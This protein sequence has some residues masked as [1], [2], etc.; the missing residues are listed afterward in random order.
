MKSKYLSQ[1]E[2]LGPMAAPAPGEMTT[3]LDMTSVQR[4]MTS[5]SSFFVVSVGSLR[6]QLV[7][8][9]VG[10]AQFPAGGSMPAESPATEDARH[11]ADF[12]GIYET[13]VHFWA[14]RLVLFVQQKDAML[15]A[16]L[17]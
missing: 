14:D 10:F 12:G 5:T 8:C 7:S 16:A 17:V 2:L 13:R 6:L 15:C 1:V 4:G 9:F 3:T 11:Q